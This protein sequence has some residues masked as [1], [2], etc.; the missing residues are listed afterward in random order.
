MISSIIL[1]RVLSFFFFKER[2]EKLVNKYEN[3]GFANGS[4]CMGSIGLLYVFNNVH[5][6]VL[7]CVIED[8]LVLD[9][10]HQQE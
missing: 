10:H 1:H 9:L 2:S 7:S 8:H 3:G 6:S 4:Y 5:V